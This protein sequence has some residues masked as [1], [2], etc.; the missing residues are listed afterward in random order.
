[1]L[2][3]C[4]YSAHIITPRSPLF[5]WLRIHT[6]K[7]HLLLVPTA[8]CHPYTPFSPLCLCVSVLSRLRAWLAITS[9]DIPSATKPPAASYCPPLQSLSVWLS[10]LFV[11]CPPLKRVRHIGDPIIVQSITFNYVP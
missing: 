3:P 7:L 9:A 1:M 11:D 5:S 6:T 4:P 8:L 2:N 10:C